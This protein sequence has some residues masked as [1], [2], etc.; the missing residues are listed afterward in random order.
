VSIFERTNID[1][2]ENRVDL[3]VQCSQCGGAK[4]VKDNHKCGRTVCAGGDCKKKFVGCDDMI[5][6]RGYR[7]R[8][9]CLD[10]GHTWTEMYPI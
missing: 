1:R 2:P 7:V 5:S 10:C 4:V 8:Y 9:K 6:R 3:S